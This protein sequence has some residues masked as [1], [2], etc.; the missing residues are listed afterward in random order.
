[1]ATV[2][3]L[4]KTKKRK[5][6]KPYFYAIFFLFEDADRLHGMKIETFYTGPAAG[7]IFGLEIKRIFDFFEPTSN[8][9]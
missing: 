3:L 5:T 6:L 7:Q 9:C 1:M 2:T 4:Q 8:V